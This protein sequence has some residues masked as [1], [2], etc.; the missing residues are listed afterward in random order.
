MHDHAEM[1]T[2]MRLLTL[3][4]ALSV[5]AAA[6]GAAHGSLFFLFDPTHAAHGDEVVIRTGGTPRSFHLGDR[7][8]PFQ[9]P[10]RVYLVPEAV[11]ASV[12]S[13][14]D[15]RLALIGILVPDKNGHGV[16]TF[17]VQQLHTGTY[18]VAAWCPGCAADSFGR[19]FFTFPDDPQIVPRY[20]ALMFL[21]IE[22]GGS[23][24][25]WWI[26]SAVAFVPVAL[27]VLFA[28][29]RARVRLELPG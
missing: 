23:A 22:R 4:V 7:V 21:Q 10:I 13:R 12:R 17:R 9:S 25:W 3:L 2:T 27:G 18:A 20:R 14:T 28:R 6:T 11:A 24:P 16:L 1:S 29:K 26:I 8:R 19:R 5:A 15:P